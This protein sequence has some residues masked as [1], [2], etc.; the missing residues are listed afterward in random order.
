[1]LID[2]PDPTVCITLEG[3]VLFQKDVLKLFTILSYS[4]PYLSFYDPLVSPEPKG[5]YLS[6]SVR[7]VTAGLSQTASHFGKSTL[8]A[9]IG[10]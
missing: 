8:H 10:Q 1:M 5:L 4:N 6:H 7:L 2:W 3:F 9:P